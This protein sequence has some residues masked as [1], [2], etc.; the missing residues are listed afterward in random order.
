MQKE[1]YLKNRNKSIKS[2][3]NKK[4][5]SYSIIKNELSNR[6][7]ILYNFKRYQKDIKAKEQEE[8][9]S[10][11]VNKTTTRNLKQK[12][13]DNSKYKYRINNLSSYI[14]VFPQEKRTRKISNK[15]I[16][17]NNSF[18]NNINILKISNKKS[19]TKR[20]PNIKKNTMKNINNKIPQNNFLNIN[21]SPFQ[22]DKIYQ[23]ELYIEP[24]ETSYDNEF[25][26]F[27]NKKVLTTFIQIE[28]LTKIPDRIGGRKNKYAE[29]EYNE[30][31]RAAVTCRRI[32]YSY[33]LRNVIKS[34][35]CLDEVILIQRWWREILRK[36][37]EEILK[38]LYL[39]E[40][41]NLD[42]IKR[43]ILFLNKIHYIYI[44]HL[45]KNFINNIKMKY[46]KLYN[47]NYLSRYAIKIQRA[48]RQFIKKRKSES[49]NKLSDLL[50]KY[51]YKIK[52]SLLF[53]EFENI[54]MIINKLKYL[55]N[56]I[57]YYFL[58]RNEK[59]Y[60]KVAHEEHPLLYYYFKYRI[61]NNPKSY[62]RI[63]QKIF[64]FLFYVNKWK[65][66]FRYQRIKK[67][68]LFLDIIKFILKKKFFMYFILRLVE[69]INAMIT[70]FLL[71]PL[72][73]HILQK[74]YL[75]KIRKAFYVWKTKDQ[76]LKRKNKL[77]IKLI[78]KIIRI[79]TLEYF[80]KQLKNEKKLI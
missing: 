18:Q 24:K 57:K 38:E 42:N 20:H 13:I 32:E 11:V 73:K 10:N 46:A 49:K 29:Y 1:Q 12:S 56:F 2:I 69:R 61:K 17:I 26:K 68:I 36:R 75:N 6:A 47:K 27:H 65:K 72:M 52:K 79:Y 54:C 30:A 5:K 77:A 37:N 63:K 59:Y 7:K 43:Y 74:Y 19:N 9:K 34:E 64:R 51:F 40:K 76:N 35:I 71:Q 16:N 67:C 58:R 41:I 15:K 45:L 8:S 39:Y 3:D 21:H 62:R 50:N 55:Q 70:Y 66:F 78:T 48:F 31:K 14:N 60:L 4:H 22:N 25:T 44:L 80:L 23:N 33:N 28:D 53:N